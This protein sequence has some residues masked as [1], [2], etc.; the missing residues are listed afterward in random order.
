MQAQEYSRPHR[1]PWFSPIEQAPREPQVHAPIR[2]DAHTGLTED[3][4]REPDGVPHSVVGLTAG[5][6]LIFAVLLFVLLIIHSTVGKV[7]AIML[8]LLAVPVLVKKLNKKAQRDR[9][10]L[11]PSV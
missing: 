2:D 8:L 3:L 5:F 6:S 10:H 7:G 11:H 9:D 4:D 1:S